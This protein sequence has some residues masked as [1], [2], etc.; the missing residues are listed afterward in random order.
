[1]IEYH[2]K[3][4]SFKDKNRSKWTD[5]AHGQNPNP[6]KQRR[7]S[8]LLKQ[9]TIEYQKKR[10]DAYRRLMDGDE[11]VAPEDSSSKLGFK[12]LAKRFRSKTTTGSSND[13]HQDSTSRQSGEMLVPLTRQASEPAHQSDS[14]AAI[15]AAGQGLMRMH[16]SW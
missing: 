2:A 14:I 16:T 7:A 5:A 8:N 4:G 15:E 9:Q 1:M 3:K 11:A 6:V 13:A 12:G 10:D